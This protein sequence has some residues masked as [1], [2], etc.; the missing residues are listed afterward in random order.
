MSLEFKPVYF[1]DKIQIVSP[2]LRYEKEKLN[3]VNP[4]GTAGVITL[5]TKPWDVWERLKVSYPRVF[6]SDSS[7]VTLTSLY[8]NGLPQML[9]NLIHNPQ[10]EYLAVIG[11]ETTAVPSFSYLMNFLENGVEQPVK[12]GQLGTIRNTQYPIDPQLSPTLLQYLKIQRF[13]LSNLESLVSFISQ[14]PNRNPEEK[15]RARI[16]LLEPEFSDFPSAIDAF[17]LRA[18]TPLTAWLDVVYHID[19]FGQNLEIKKGTRRRLYN[20][21]VII[22]DPSPEKDELLLE[23]GFDPKE[24]KSYRDIMLQEELPKGISYTYG[25]L[26]RRYFGF[27]TLKKVITRLKNDNLDRRAFISLW[28]NK[29]HLLAS[30]ES[31]TSVPCLTDLF[32]IYNGGSLMLDA[33]FRTH[34]AV[35]AWLHNLY[36][37]RALQEYVSEQT[38]LIPGPIKVESRWIGI[39]PNDAR[40]N[41]ALEI[42][43]EKR[44]K[45]LDVD[46]PRGY[47]SIDVEGGLIVLHHY[48]PNHQRLKT[49]RGKSSRD[50]G[51]QLRQDS[52][53]VIPDHAMWIGHE[54]ARV[55][56]LLRGSLEEL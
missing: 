13:E 25:N 48:S 56:W 1:G 27:D 45:R 6:S 17:A 46:D 54:L 40:T 32:F 28:D 53:I 2:D 9:S 3:V 42:I 7:L 34:N 39:D 26:L 50:I 36:G 49:Y 51:D 19:R 24:V 10:I 38:S 29:A 33:S 4:L 5:W 55:E 12:E 22:E 20:L 21:Q 30:T 31:D 18:K 41:K 15:D 8:G 14:K 47:F 43:K 11:S 37:L 52:A 16:R 23:Y 35:S 44:R